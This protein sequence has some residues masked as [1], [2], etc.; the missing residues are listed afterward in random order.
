MKALKIALKV[1]G[2]AGF[3]GSVQITNALATAL[4]PITGF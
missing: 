3:I 4:A 1:I 2:T